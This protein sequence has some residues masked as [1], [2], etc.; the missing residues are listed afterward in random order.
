MVGYMGYRS[1]TKGGLIMETSCSYCH[2]I[3]N[4]FYSFGC[5]DD[6]I[7][8]CIACCPRLLQDLERAIEYVNHRDTW[9]YDRYLSEG[10]GPSN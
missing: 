8:I 1:V 9:S 3:T 6:N 5:P 4:Q 2:R 10:S 7:D